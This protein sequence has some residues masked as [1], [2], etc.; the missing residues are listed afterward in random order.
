MSFVAAAGLAVGIGGMVG[1]GIARSKANKQLSKLQGQDPIYQENPLAAQRLGLANTLLNARMPGASQAQRN[2]QTAG[3]NT[4]AGAQRN[5]TSGAQALSVG[6]AVN[7]QQGQQFNDL[8]QQEAQDYQRRYGN[9]VGAQEGMINEQQNVFQDEVRRFGDKTQIQGAQ[10]ENR[11]NT[12]GDVSRL[13]FGVADL[14]MAG[15]FNQFKGMFGGGGSQGM[16][17]QQRQAF[18]PQ[19]STMGG[20]TPQGTGGINPYFTPYI[21]GFNPNTNRA[22][23][24]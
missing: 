20:A 3:A 15:G 21:G 14:G 6:T 18:N 12:W 22:L 24:G 23:N 2:I 17:G 9:L 5:A 19:M 11:A 7:A 8:G 4:V 16:A 10:A 1:K 13:G